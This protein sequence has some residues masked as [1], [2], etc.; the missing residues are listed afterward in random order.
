MTTT[1][2]LNFIWEMGRTTYKQPATT[3]TS[4]ALRMAK[5]TSKLH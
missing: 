1:E 4:S 2:F 5:C 3:G